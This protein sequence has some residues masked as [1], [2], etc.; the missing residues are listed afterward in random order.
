MAK[1]RVGR[2]P[3]EFKRMVVERLKQCDS[4][5]ALAAELDL[6]RRLMYK[7][8]DQLDPVGR[9]ATA[10]QSSEQR[11]RQRSIRIGAGKQRQRLE[12]WFS[13]Q[14][15]FQLLPNSDTVVRSRA[16]TPRLLQLARRPCPAVN[17]SARSSRPCPLWPPHY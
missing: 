2:Y 14:E 12:A 10:R 5:V 15:L 4:I 1:R 8:R 6:D 13:L 9:E 7:W 11:G 3:H 16:I 17:T